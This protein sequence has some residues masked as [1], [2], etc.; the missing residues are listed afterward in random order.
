MAR[1][2]RELWRIS[3]KLLPND[4]S[5][6]KF[7]VRGDNGE[8]NMDQMQVG[9]LFERLEGWDPL[10]NAL[11]QQLRSALVVDHNEYTA[12]I[13]TTRLD[14]RNKGLVGREKAS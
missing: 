10:P 6:V 12:T 9:E 3:F 5:R 8:V 7:I 14:L 13:R 4:E 11:Y 2:T 1:Q